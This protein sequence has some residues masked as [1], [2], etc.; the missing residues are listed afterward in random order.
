MKFLLQI[1]WKQVIEFHEIPATDTLER[2]YI[3][4]YAPVADSS[5]TN[6]FRSDRIAIQNFN[7]QQLLIF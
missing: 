6:I 1:L 2:A 4:L 3:Y 7:L 5:V